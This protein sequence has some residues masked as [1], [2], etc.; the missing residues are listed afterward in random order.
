METINEILSE[1]QKFSHFVTISDIQSI[2]IIVRILVI[3]CY[4]AKIEIFLETLEKLPSTSQ[5]LG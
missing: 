5:A 1:N 2:N 4:R 3:C